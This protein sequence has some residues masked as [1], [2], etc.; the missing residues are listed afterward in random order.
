MSKIKHWISAFRFR[1]LLLAV[2]GVTLGTGLAIH[3]GSFSL[4]TLI[5]AL[6]LAVSIQVLSNLANDLGDFQK[7]TDTTGNRQGPTRAVQSGN[8]TPKEMKRAIIIN[9]ALVLIIGLVL[10]FTSITSFNS[11]SLYI[12]IGLGLISILAAL[13]YTLGNNAYGYSG[14]GDIFAFFFFGPVAVI[15]TFFLH[16]NQFNT[17]PL[18][19]AI[20]LGLISTMILNVNNMRDIDNDKASGKRTV[21]T[22]IG[23]LNAKRYHLAMTLGVLA[24]FL[25]YSFIY[26]TQPWY[27][28]AYIIVFILLIKVIKDIW[29]KEG[30]ELDPYLKKTAI[31]GLILAT[32]FSIC[33]N[34]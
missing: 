20:G 14:W 23:L 32:A 3:T 4:S 29:N 26:A 13:F 17:Q 6:L 16:T 28:F 21:A 2:A 33:I 34:I 25:S 24:S 15:G 22:K 19:P 9:I 1:T 18:L 12:L 11:L 30:Q 10:V 27:S 31:A 5:L 7:G 8:I